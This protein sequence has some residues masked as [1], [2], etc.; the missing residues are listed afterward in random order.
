MLQSAFVRFTI[1]ITVLIAT[2][3]ASM[4][5][6]VV[7]STESFP[8]DALPDVM[9]VAISTGAGAAVVRL[10]QLRGAPV[11]APLARNTSG[12]PDA[13]HCLAITETVAQIRQRQVIGYVWWTQQLDDDGVVSATARR[14]D[15]LMAMPALLIAVAVSQVLAWWLRRRSRRSADTP[16]RRTT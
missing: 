14:A 2:L 4:A 10:G 7:G 16:R 6:F 5:A 12:C 1:R 9:P 3:L 8:A 15:A 11:N 13:V